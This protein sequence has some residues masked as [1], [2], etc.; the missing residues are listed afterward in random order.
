LRELLSHLRDLFDYPRE[1]FICPREMFV[2]P[3]EM[4]ARFSE[5]FVYLRH[6]RVVLGLTLYQ[7]LDGPL[8]FVAG[9][10]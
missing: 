1:L 8:K 2:C 10:V 4:L 5:V 3:R 7:K 6:A 9:H